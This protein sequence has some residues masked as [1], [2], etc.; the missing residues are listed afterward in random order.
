MIKEIQRKLSLVLLLTGLVGCS[1]VSDS[2]VP[3]EREQIGFE[4]IEIQSPKSFR[5]WISPEITY[6]EFEALEVPPG[7]I[8]NQPRES[9]E[10]PADMVR[11][12]KSP[13]A[14]MDGDIL[15]EEFYGY[16]WFHAATVTDP[17]VVLDE[18]RLLR[19]NRVRKFHEITYN[20]GRRL[21]LLISPEGAVYLRVGRDANRVNDEP[22]IPNLWRIEEY[23]TP[24]KLVIELFGE[25]LVIRTDNEDSFQGPVPELENAL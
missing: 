19:G 1:D 11:F 12:I 22:T 23:V 10:T 21:I 2:Q 7:W 17:N 6:Q 5:A 18:E 20:A 24:E 8:K 16:K 13:D 14:T 4:I 3:P 9:T 15:V 25:T